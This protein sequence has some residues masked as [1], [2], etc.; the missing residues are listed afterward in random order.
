MSNAINLFD[1]APVTKKSSA[2]KADKDQ[3]II[4]EA[5][6]HTSVHRLAEIVALKEA[7]EAE[8][9][10]LADDVKLRSIEEFAK[11]YNTT[12][13]YPGSFNVVA[14]GAKGKKDATYMFLP[15]DKYIMLNEDSYNFLKETYGEEIVEKNVSYAMDTKLIEK[16]GKEISAA[17]MGCKGIPEADKKALITREI[18]W[19]VKKGTIKNLKAFAAPISQLVANILPV[20]QRKIIRIVE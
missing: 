5:A 16:Y 20:F 14:T 8:E 18:K 3:I 7:L 1:E 15:T 4:K 11:L 13:V 2:A 19:S 17:I 6:F 12:G 10:S 9:K